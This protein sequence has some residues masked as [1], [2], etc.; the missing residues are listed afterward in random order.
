[1][2]LF[3]NRIQPTIV[4][5]GDY[6]NINIANK[7][8]LNYNVVQID[9]FANNSIVM[10]D[11]SGI[12]VLESADDS[13][14]IGSLSH[15]LMDLFVD[16]V[17]S[18]VTPLDIPRIYFA[19]NDKF[20]SN[21]GECETPN[22]INS[23]ITTL[24]GLSDNCVEHNE[25][26]ETSFITEF[27]TNGDTFNGISLV[28]GEDYFINE[29]FAKY[30][31]HI[32]LRVEYPDLVEPESNIGILINK[33]DSITLPNY[34]DAESNI[35][36]PWLQLTKT[37]ENNTDL[38]L[39]FNINTLSELI[40][41]YNVNDFYSSFCQIIL[42]KSTIN[43][44]AT[45][46]NNLKYKKVLEYFINGK[47]DEASVLISLILGSK[48]TAETV[49]TGSSLCKCGTNNSATGLST[50]SSLYYAAMEEHL[51][52]MLGNIQFYVDWFFDYTDNSREV[53]KD[54]IKH[55]KLL[56]KAFIDK[57]YDLSFTNNTYSIPCKCPTDN[58]Q[59]LTSKTNYDII[60]KYD[61]VLNYILS[62]TLQ[63]NI[64]KI[65]IYG[66]Q[67]GGLLPK[68]QF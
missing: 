10:E 11:G 65:K 5:L 6:E 17:H 4:H 2:D 25:N 15:D 36:E 44:N 34:L 46:L 63:Y 38:S 31:K 35:Q 27:I 18:G 32:D 3:K 61:N 64:N 28:P 40:N 43:I 42:E 9:W 13:N 54:L 45:D 26:D 47:T 7:Y 33:I 51:K 12:L 23:F 57:G 53:N 52:E 41:Q 56:I 67:F 62:C 48:Y 49:N 59:S 16:G 24:I 30:L 20:L 66:S 29:T 1:M 22:V 21:A 50:C 19:I 58:S 39:Y 55:L 68:L 37:E 8:F 60:N 14:P